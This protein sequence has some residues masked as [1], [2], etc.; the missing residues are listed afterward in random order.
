VLSTGAYSARQPTGLL[1]LV[2]RVG[3]TKRPVGASAQVGQGER[4]MAVDPL[5]LVIEGGRE[6]LAGAA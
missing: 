2:C 1:L 5:S 4:V 6:E 3:V